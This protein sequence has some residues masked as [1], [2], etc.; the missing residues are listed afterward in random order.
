MRQDSISALWYQV[1]GDSQGAQ[2]ERL[3]ARLE[4]WQTSLT[5]VVESTPDQT[6]WYQD[7]IVYALY[8][9]AFAGDFDGLTRRLDY[10]QTLG[11][12]TLWLLPILDSPMRDQ[13]FDIRDFRAI[14]GELGGN[15]A[16]LR[17]I[18]SAH[19][20]GIRLLFDMAVNHS[21]DEHPWFREA[22]NDPESPY[23][24]YYIWSPDTRPYSQARLL[25]KG[26]VDS[27]WEL[28][29]P[30][31]DYYFHRFYAFQP[32]LN[33]RNPELFLEMLDNFLFWQAQ[34]V[35]GL[36]MDAIPFIWKEEGTQCEDLPEVHILLKL[37]RACLDRVKPGTL[38]IAEAN[39]EPRQV[40]SYFGQDDEC[41]A[42]YHFPLL[43]QFYLALAEGDYRPIRDALLPERTPPI[44][45]HSRWMAFL[46]CHDELTLEFVSPDERAR[47]NQY[48]LQDAKYSFREGEGIAG[49]L[50]DLL[51][52]DP[53]KVL[54]MH[55]MLFATEGS[56]ILYYGDEVGMGNDE[57]F[58]AEH[59]RRTGFPDGRF[60]NRGPMDWDRVERAFTDPESPAHHIFS[61]LQ[62]LIRARRELAPIFRQRGI[63]VESDD[64]A[65]FCVQRQVG[66]HQVRVC[67]NL[68][69]D[70]RTLNLPLPMHD[71]LGG[72]DAGRQVV[73]GPWS[74]CWL[75]VS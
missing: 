25:F 54:L 5:P 17:F 71:V 22:A 4:A 46:R 9:D 34:G 64:P 27:N 47:M 30:T 33:Y 1:Y 26:M 73:L 48:Y 52:Q 18:E 14:R 75:Q 56:P 68:S 13:G 51:G 72:A 74:Y 10:L 50:F 38:L 32:D 58:F 69:A 44:P 3:H 24:N 29:P 37:I 31:G 23:R 20:R 7:A 19:D 65:L 35:D 55:S 2:L 62:A 59:S 42:A 15:S 21:S 6:N 45:P 41:Q 43:P 8:V 70:H 63:I 36:R 40:V 12:N 66:S 57:A 11:V 49:R 16:F 39:M 61:G 60:Y 28:N 67:H 53:D